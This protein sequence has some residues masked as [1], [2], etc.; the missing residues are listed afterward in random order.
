MAIKANMV[1]DQGTDFSRS[2]SV[3]TSNGSI[4]DLTN[5]TAVCGLKKHFSS[6][7][8]YLLT[9]VVSTPAAGEITITANNAVTSAIPPGRYNY[10]VEVTSNTASVDRVLQGQITVTPEHV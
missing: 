4:F 7:T 1:M 10:D 9:A 2:V 8:S 6:N 5:Y 3:T